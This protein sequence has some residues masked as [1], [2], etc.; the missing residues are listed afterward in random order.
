MVRLYYICQQSFSQR[1]GLFTLQELI[2]TLSEYGYKSLHQTG[3]KK[4]KIQS[5]KKI[6]QACPLLFTH[7]KNDLFKI[8]SKYK[9]HKMT[10]SYRSI[11]IR[12]L[13]LSCKREFTDLMIGIIAD[14]KTVDY[15]TLSKAT[16]Y[17]RARICQAMQGN[18]KKKH[19]L[20]INNNVVLEKFHS[21]N[22]AEIFRLQAFKNNQI[23]TKIIKKGSVYYIVVPGANSYTSIMSA[24]K[25]GSCRPIM[26]A[27]H[28]SPVFHRSNGLCFFKDE[29]QKNNFIWRHCRD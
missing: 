2:L 28:D 26:T 8:N 16:G 9:I 24:F 15:I 11:D 13:Q 1:S 19:I 12:L 14:L 20:K 21:L 25:Y 5:I 3:N 6:L 22:D 17:T 4:K 18:H 23:I 27:Q 29:E 7:C 10:P